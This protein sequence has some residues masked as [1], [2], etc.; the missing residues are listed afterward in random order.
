LAYDPAFAATGGLQSHRGEYH[1]EMKLAAH[2]VVSTMA[3]LL[4]EED[5]EGAK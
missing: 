4:K 2:L 1:T 3:I 5:G